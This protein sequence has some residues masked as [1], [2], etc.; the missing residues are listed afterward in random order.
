L[1]FLRSNGDQGRF[2][3]ALQERGVSR[4]RL[5]NFERPIK[6]DPEFYADRKDA[7]VKDFENFQR[8]LKSVHSGTDL[9][10]AAGA[11]RS[12]LNEALQRQLAA[13]LAMRQDQR[14]A[15]EIVT[16]AGAV[17]EGL[18]EGLAAT[19]DSAVLRDLL[20]LDLALEELQRATIE[21][22]PLNQF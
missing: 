14:P 15:A 3:Q 2:C 17:R 4:E 9:D 10:S 18:R 13:V 1:A 7:L 21:Q 22:Q 5:R 16:A 8:V 6:T 19:R 20:F 12:R 11:A